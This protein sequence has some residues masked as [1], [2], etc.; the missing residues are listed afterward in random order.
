MF[1]PF[2]AAFVPHFACS[3]HK[4]HCFS[5]FSLEHGVKLKM[6]SGDRR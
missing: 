6:P 1:I 3:L 4:H 2:A 5:F